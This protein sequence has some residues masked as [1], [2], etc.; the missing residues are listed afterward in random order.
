MPICARFTFSRLSHSA[1]TG[2]LS[3]DILHM[4]LLAFLCLAIHYLSGCAAIMLPY[5]GVILPS[6]SSTVLSHLSFWR[7]S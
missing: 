6:P 4:M 3:H 7:L 2:S 5:Q 1:S